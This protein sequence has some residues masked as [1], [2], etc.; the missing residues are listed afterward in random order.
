MPVITKA[1]LGAKMIEYAT[2]D[3]KR[4]EYDAKPIEYAKSASVMYRGQYDNCIPQWVEDPIDSVSDEDLAL[5]E[6]F[7]DPVATS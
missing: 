4:N 6:S 7:V 3:T 2:S 1:E 5:G